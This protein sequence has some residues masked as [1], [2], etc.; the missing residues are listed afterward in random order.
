MKADEFQ[1]ILEAAEWNQVQLADYLVRHPR[2]VRRWLHGEVRIPE[3]VARAVRNTP[4]LV[5]FDLW[6]QTVRGIGG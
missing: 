6:L 1:D 5:A 2:T 3:V 4:R